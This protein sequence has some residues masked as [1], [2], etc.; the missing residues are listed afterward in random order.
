MSPSGS[1][2]TRL[3]PSFFP[4]QPP[5]RV[6]RLFFGGG[7]ISGEGGGYGFGHISETDSIA[8]LKK[9]FEKGIR[10]SDTAPI[11]GFGT[12]E[13]RIG[14][15]FQEMRS[16]MKITTKGGVDWHPDR[17]VNMDNTP[18]TLKRMLGESLQRLQTSSVD[19][20]M[21]HWPDARVP[22]TES[23]DVLIQAQIEGQIKSLGLSN[24]TPAQIEEAQKYCATK[25]QRIEFIQAERSFLKEANGELPKWCHENGLYFMSWGSLDKGILTNRVTS[26]R[27]FDEVDARRNAIWWKKDTDKDHRIQLVQHLKAILDQHQISPLRW[28][29][30]YNLD[31]AECDFVLFAPRN[32][33]QLE[34]GIVAVQ[35]PIEANVFETIIEEFHKRCRTAGLV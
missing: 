6:E 33:E 17:R 24:F 31:F 27:Q 2:N 16:E 22:L 13:T 11:Y 9:A 10:V 32:L 18:A 34:S 29:L 23:L 20:Y 14:K 4:N 19:C 21:I 28:S 1:T 5:T 30:S 12:S 3:L 26:S 35:E 25:N 7:A 8:L 15:A